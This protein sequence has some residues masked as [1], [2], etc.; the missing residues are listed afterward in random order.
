MEPVTSSYED[1]LRT[2]RTGKNTSSPLNS[3]K[4]YMS[5]GRDNDGLLTTVGKDGP[6]ATGTSSILSWPPWASPST[7]QAPFYDTFGLTMMQRY[8]A[9]GL[10]MLGAV[11]LFFLAFVH[12]PMV[13][14]R[15]SKF[16]V[17]YCLSNMLLF[18]SFGFLHGFYSY[19][20]HLFSSDRWPYSTAFLGATM[21]TLY[22]AMVM[23]MYA[24]TIPM[25]I[26][27]FIAMLAFMVSYM[28]GGTSGISM[29][30]SFATNSIRSRV[31]GF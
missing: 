4:R 14:L 20:R 16:V 19:G 17:P 8:A 3:L 7:Q 2:M 5:W 21:A 31:A 6:T 25:A 15:P 9:F 24:L 10:C 12:L 28:P 11:L 13:I 27:Q 1:T 23:R 26:V 30:G 18:F 22:V 29:M